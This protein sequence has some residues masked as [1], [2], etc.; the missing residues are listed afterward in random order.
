[1]VLAGNP[2]PRQSLQGAAGW[3]VRG[4]PS[5][6][7]SSPIRRLLLLIVLLFALIIGILILLAGLGSRVSSGVRAFIGGEGHWS[8]AQKNAALSLSRY[9]ATGEPADY[10]SFRDLLPKSDPLG[11]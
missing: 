9:T 7:R 5:R 4:D 11:T 10:E 2:V 8:R 3:P 1:M 6:R